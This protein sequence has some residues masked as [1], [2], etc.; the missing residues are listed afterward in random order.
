M[1]N[2][3]NKK[4]I[5]ANWKMNME[6]PA[7]LALFSGVIDMIHA[8]VTGAQQT[9]VCCPFIHLHALV[10][11]AVGHAAISVGAENCHEAESGAFTGEI[12]AGMIRSTARIMSS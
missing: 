5:T 10:Q 1:S 6:Y 3:E 2:D 9:V 7:G 11:P 8:E 12:S 4:I